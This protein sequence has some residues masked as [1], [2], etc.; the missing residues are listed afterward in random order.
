MT[1]VGHLAMG[2]LP[3]GSHVNYVTLK[4]L[5]ILLFKYTLKDFKNAKNEKYYFLHPEHFLPSLADK[6]GR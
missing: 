3:C 4:H 1:H 2:A 5:Q 6:N